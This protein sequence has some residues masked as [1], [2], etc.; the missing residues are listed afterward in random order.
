MNADQK[1]RQAAKAKSGAK[2]SLGI[3]GNRDERTRRQRERPRF[4]SEKP[5]FD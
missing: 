4:Q 5:F 2:Q 1:K 3:P